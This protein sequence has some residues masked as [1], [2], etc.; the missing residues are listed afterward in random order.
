MPLARQGIPVS[1]DPA[2]PSY[3]QCGADVVAP[4]PMILTVLGQLGVKLP[5]S[6]VGM[7]T[8]LVPKVCSEL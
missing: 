1:L 8:K 2:G 7:D 4:S 5:L 3:S 6:D